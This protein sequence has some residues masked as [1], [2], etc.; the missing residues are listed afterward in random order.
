MSQAT[1][2]KNKAIVSRWIDE[3][4]NGKN[5]GAVE[6]L[7]FLSYLDWTPFPSQQLDLPISGLKRSLPEFFAALPDFHFTADEMFAEGDMVVCLG[8][9]KGTHLGEFLGVPPTGQTVTGNRIDIFRLA[10]DKMSEHSGC[11]GELGALRLLGAISAPGQNGH[12]PADPK[13][14]ARG[15]VEQVINQRN[16]AAID[17]LVDASAVDHSNQALESFTLLSALPDYRVSV[18]DVIAEGDTVIVRSTFSG[19][20]LGAYAGI[21]P[22]GKPVSGARTDTFRVQHGKIVESWQDWDSASLLDQIRA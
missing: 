5:L 15:F 3:V 9:W 6:S 19:T 16:L 21:E 10:G 14:V 1:M 2:E 13:A 17:E 11:G 18:E 8:S 12:D 22:T 7:K 20:H 4:F